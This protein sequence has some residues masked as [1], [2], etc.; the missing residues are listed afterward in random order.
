MG[1]VN[2]LVVI[3]NLFIYF[4]CLNPAESHLKQALGSKDLACY[5]LV[6]GGLD[7][8][9]SATH[10]CIIVIMFLFKSRAILQ[11]YKKN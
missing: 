11:Y 10:F 5:D 2:S 1:F 4:S 6:F 9:S 7:T 3:A 8:I